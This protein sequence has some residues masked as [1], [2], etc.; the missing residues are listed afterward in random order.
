VGLAGE[1]GTTSFQVLVTTSAAASRARAGLNHVRFLVVDSFEPDA[2]ENTLRN[3][4]ESIKEH[5]WDKI[6]EDLRRSMYYEY[7]KEW[8]PARE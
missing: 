8:R 7:D 6:L 4:V 3:R 2:V 1:Q 5:T